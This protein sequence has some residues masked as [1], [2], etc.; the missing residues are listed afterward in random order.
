M[1]IRCTHYSSQFLCTTIYGSLQ[2][3]K[4]K[5]LWEYVGSVAEQIIEPWVIA[6]DF[7]VILDSSERIGGADSTR[8]G[9]L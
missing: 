5:I 1:R 7:N 2:P 6:E 4:R 3:T 9:C 8:N